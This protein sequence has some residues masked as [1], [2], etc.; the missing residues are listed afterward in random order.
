VQDVLRLATRGGASCLG[1]DDIGRLE[2]G[3]CADGAVTPGGDLREIAGSY[4]ALLF[5]L[6]RVR[7]SLVGGELV[8]RDGRVAG[9]D[10]PAARRRL[11]ACRRAC[12]G[13]AHPRDAA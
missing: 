8:V 2:P 9:V 10:L 1:R 5:G 4:A 13:A 12:A 11:D 7:H 6:D 3:A